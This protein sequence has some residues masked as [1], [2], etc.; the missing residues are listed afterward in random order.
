M[1]NLKILINRKDKYVKIINFLR[2]ISINHNQIQKGPE[3][4]ELDFHQDN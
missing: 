2:F 3:L 1:L 4:Q